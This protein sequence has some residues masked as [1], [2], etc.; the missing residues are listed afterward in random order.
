[1]KWWDDLK[2]RFSE[3]A[4]SVSDKSYELSTI[5][6]LRWEIFS[7]E[8]DIDHLKN[9]LGGKVYQFQVENKQQDLVKETNDIVEK[10]KDAEKQLK[11]KESQLEELTNKTVVDG[12]KL[13]QFKKDLELGDGSIDQFV[14]TENS[15]LIGKKLMD[16]KLPKNVLVGAI[17]RKEKVVIPDGKTTFKQDDKVTLLGE[18]DDVQKVLET[19]GK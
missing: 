12:H 10:L 2:A 1:M 6:K 11:E 7:I 13:K 14:V 8:K 18:K 4:K 3:S 9:E 5:A 15:E 17:V 16:I 19:M